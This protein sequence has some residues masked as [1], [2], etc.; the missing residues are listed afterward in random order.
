[1]SELRTALALPLPL[2]LFDNGSST[3]DSMSSSPEEATTTCFLRLDEG[4]WEETAGEDFTD[5]DGLRED[6]DDDDAF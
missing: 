2:L 3:S 4:V 5:V 1:M 6:D